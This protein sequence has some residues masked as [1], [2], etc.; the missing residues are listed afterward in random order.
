MLRIASLLLLS[1]IAALAADP[2]RVLVWD[3]R[4]PRQDQAT[5]TFWAMR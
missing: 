3:E 4:Q 5:R 2:V 1:A